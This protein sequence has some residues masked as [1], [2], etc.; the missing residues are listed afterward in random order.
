MPGAFALK[1]PTTAPPA[2]HKAQYQGSNK[3][4]ETRYHLKFQTCSENHDVTKLLIASEVFILIPFTTAHL[5]GNPQSYQSSPGYQRSICRDKANNFLL[6]PW[7]FVFSEHHLIYLC[8]YHGSQIFQTAIST[9]CH[10]HI[11]IRINSKIQTQF[12][13]IVG[14]YSGKGNRDE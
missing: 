13:H 7:L 8:F 4:Q 3:E 10:L 14:I 11:P 5:Q 9:S 1:Q 6:S 2:P 12:E